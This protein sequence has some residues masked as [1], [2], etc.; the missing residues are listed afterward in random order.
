MQLAIT[1]GLSVGGGIA[2]LLVLGFLWEAACEALARRPAPG[3]L[4]DVGSGRRMH[5]RTKGDAAGPTVILEMG[6]A[7][8]AP[9]W[10]EIQDAVSRFARVC[11]YDRAGFG[12]SDR[13]REPISLEGR[14]ADLHAVLTAAK[15]PGPYVLVGHSL[16]GPLIRLYARDHG[17]MTAGLVFVDTPDEAG[18]F[19]DGYLAFARKGMK[20]MMATM[21]LATRFGVMRLI[22]LLFPNNPFAPQ[23][24]SEAKRALAA[25]RDPRTFRVAVGEFDSIIN[26]P[27]GLRREN[28]LGGP[29]GDKPIVVITHGQKF[30][31]PYDV[32]E[33]GWDEGQQRLAAL[34]TNSTLIVAEKSNHMIQHDE[35]DLVVEAIRS[36]WFAAR[37]SKKLSAAA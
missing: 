13:P 29:V 18:M 31:P 30:P 27:P 25:T 36:V 1:I 15:V 11:T 21:G 9:Y 14:A 20:P 2:G 33:V 10:W 4:V 19:R 12:W 17:D 22:N 32:L 24:K 16:G 6:A 23:V 35:P 26:A 28:G 7:E 3:L 37:D 5:I 8:P 34:S